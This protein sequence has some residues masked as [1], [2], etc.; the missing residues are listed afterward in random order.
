MLLFEQVLKC[1]SCRCH[2]VL[3]G[4][5]V[6]AVYG[7]TK[8]AH[9]QKITALG[10]YRHVITFAQQIIHQSPSDEACPVG[11]WVVSGAH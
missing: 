9:V 10:A 6:S 8:Y 7:R 11:P 5:K 1:R 2:I 4:R 3:P